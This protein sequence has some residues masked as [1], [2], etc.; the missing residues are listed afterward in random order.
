MHPSILLHGQSGTGKTTTARIIARYVNCE[1]L[2][3]D[4]DGHA[5]PCGKCSSCKYE[6][7]KHP[8]VFEVN[9]ANFRG[10]DEVRTLTRQFQMAPTF[11]FRIFILDEVHQLTP[12]AK[13]ALLKPLEE[14]PEHVIVVMA[15]TNPEKLTPTMRGRMRQL[16]VRPLTELSCAKLLRKVCKQEGYELEKEQLLT[17]SR[18]TGAQPRA[19][20]QALGAVLDNIRFKKTQDPAEM[21]TIIKE[22]VELPPYMSATTYLKAIYSGSY[23]RALQVLETVEPVVF[24][25]IVLEQHYKASKFFIAKIQGKE[26]FDKKLYEALNDYSGLSADILSFIM[27]RLVRANSLVND[28]QVDGRFVLAAATMEIVEGVRIKMGVTKKVKE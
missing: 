16:E 28:F 14:P 2:Q 22:T 6:I 21:I 13:E 3:K 19:A 9:A 12:Q 10:I 8:D 7:D 27:T 26:W 18:L 17:I 4:E 15:T 11:N 1:D 25:K 20:L 5:Q 23:S 24:G